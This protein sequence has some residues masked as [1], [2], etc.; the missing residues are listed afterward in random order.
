[1]AAAAAAATISAVPATG[2]VMQALLD[3]PRA[4]RAC[5]LLIQLPS[6]PA[7]AASAMPEP[8]RLL[9]TSADVPNPGS[10]AGGSWLLSESGTAHLVASSKVPA[11]C[12][13]LSGEPGGRL[14]FGQCA[15]HTAASALPALAMLRAALLGLVGTL[16][17]PPAAVLE[18]NLEPNAASS[19]GV[20]RQMP[21]A[22]VTG[23]GDE[24]NVFDVDGWGG[25]GEKRGVRSAD[26]CSV[27]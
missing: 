9:P 17:T 19:A 18:L 22:A 27:A 6:L 24:V 20:G 5:T 25:A 23:C 11:V 13:R 21:A 12:V 14:L 2:E 4:S 1:M 8:S 10:H 15:P 3:V 26:C 16:A 7:R